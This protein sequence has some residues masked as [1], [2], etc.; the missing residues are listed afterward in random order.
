MRTNATL[1]GKLLAW[2][3]ALASAASLGACRGPG[4]GYQRPTLDVPAQHRDDT[5]VA[6]VSAADQAWWEVFQDPVL[7]RLVREAVANN[8]DLDLAAGR[9]EESRAYV[10]L[11]RSEGLPQ[12]DVGVDASRSGLSQ[13]GSP[14][15]ISNRH[16]S[17]IRAALGASWEL[18]LWG[19][20]R[21]S[22][23]AAWA[24]YVAS[25]HGRRA[26][27]VALVGDVAQAYLELLTLD[28]QLSVTEATVATRKSTLDLFKKRLEGGI[29]SELE[30]A[31]AAGDLA[32]VTA[33]V[34]A[35]K[36]LI[37]QKENQICLLLGRMPGPIERGVALDVTRVAPSVPA[38]L[39]STLLER[40]PDVR[41]A[42]D[43]LRAAVA[44]VGVAQAEFMPRISLTGAFGLEGDEMANVGT[45][46][47]FVWSI[48]GGILAPLFTGGRLEA[49]E[50]AAWA[51]AKQA[52]ATWKRAAQGAFR[53][54]ADALAVLRHAREV[55]QA[56]NDQVVARRRG[57]DLATQRFKGELASYFEVLDAQRELFPAEILLAS[58]KREEM[59]AVVRLYR[60][61][62]GGWNADA[63][64]PLPSPCERPEAAVPCGP[65]APC[66]ICPPNETFPGRGGKPVVPPPPA[67]PPAAPREVPPA[68][69]SGAPAR[70]PVPEPAPR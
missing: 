42:E 61:L 37:A 35:F 41:E 60:A 15:P 14:F 40:R 39:P 7:G 43:L 8:Q 51:R 21:R 25:E 62:G 48:A 27:L 30:V 68:A 33:D 63:D 55:V 38:G 57:L 49:N 31:R 66:T 46:D 58:A 16:R 10:G 20:V 36:A 19:R 69:S 3:G 6:P 59:L 64:E 1:L 5:A 28:W 17:D 56:E 29:G 53:D 44:R 67:P 13:A 45:A 12:V 50:Q 65:C 24:D 32:G 47:A 22:T 54:V 18:D 34:P 11:A 70:P 2:A 9:V 26:V 23:E 52:E 4:V